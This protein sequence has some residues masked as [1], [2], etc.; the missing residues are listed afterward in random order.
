MFVTGSLPSGR[1]HFAYGYTGNGV[2]PT[3]LAGR[4][5][6]SLALD[7]R[8][9]WTALPV[10][11]PPRDRRVPPEPLRWLGG[12]VVLAALKR[13]EAAEEREERADPLTRFVAGLP[14][15]LGI[16]VGR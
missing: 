9:E 10:V 4:V 2:G 8:D 7:L 14:R 6:A 13:A 5:L 12:S 11:D 1:V 15:R 16:T 3:Q